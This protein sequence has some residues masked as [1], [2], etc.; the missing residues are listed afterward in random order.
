MSGDPAT[1]LRALLSQI[2]ARGEVAGYAALAAAIGLTGPG[3]ISRLGGLLEATMAED[4]AA[5]RPLVASVLA[6]RTGGG[7]PAPGFFATAAALGRY[8]GPPG[9]PAA[10]AFVAAERAALAAGAA[11]PP[12]LRGP[13]R[14]AT[15]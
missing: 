13:M 4:A 9:G 7:L 3:R 8:D 5:G 12:A 1:V 6:A 14:G 11:A 2:A 15:A 10:A